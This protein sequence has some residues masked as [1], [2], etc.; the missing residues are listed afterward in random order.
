MSEKTVLVVFP[1]IYSLNKINNLATNISKILKIKNQPYENIR[2]NESLI[3]VEATDPVL[4]SSAANLLFGIEYAGLSG[5]AALQ[6]AGDDHALRGLHATG[7]RQ[8]GRQF[9]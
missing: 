1:S 3:I 5:G 7:L 8:F 9:I 4:A 2:K 6:Y